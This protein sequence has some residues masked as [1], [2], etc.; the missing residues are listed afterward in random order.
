MFASQGTSVL[1]LGVI[2]VGNVKKNTSTY[3]DVYLAVSH[4]A[5]G[6]K[7]AFVG[8]WGKRI[9]HKVRGENGDECLEDIS[10]RRKE[11]ERHTWLKG[12]EE[13]VGIVDAACI[14]RATS[15]L[16]ERY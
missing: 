9:P 6:G 11:E 7:D 1:E 10:G 16:A 12:F 3:P 5:F 8:R 13:V 2:R 14:E 4:K 15:S